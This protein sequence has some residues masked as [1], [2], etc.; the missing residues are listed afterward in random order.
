MVSEILLSEWENY[1]R[2][3]ANFDIF[4]N[5][6]LGPVCHFLHVIPT[7]LFTNL[8]KI[9]CNISSFW[10][11]KANFNFRYKNFELFLEESFII[12]Y[13][14]KVGVFYH[15][16]WRSFNLFS[17]LNFKWNLFFAVCVKHLIVSQCFAH[18]W[19]AFMFSLLIN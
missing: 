7:V 10:S 2:L 9:R 14:A 19:I 17:R 13:S 15:V 8:N 18:I 16:A 11:T 3:K 6:E 5:T 1:F 4:E 12:R